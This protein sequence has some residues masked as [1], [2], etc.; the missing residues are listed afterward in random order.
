LT[1]IPANIDQLAGADR[2]LCLGRQT[3]V[4][5]PKQS[6]MANL[7]NV[8]F[9]AKADYQ[10]EH[11][12]RLYEQH[13]KKKATLNEVARVLEDYVTRWRRWCSAGLG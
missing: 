9:S 11:L 8:C 4:T 7:I 6:F 13:A 12:P 2:L 1:T 5:D 3:A 10:T